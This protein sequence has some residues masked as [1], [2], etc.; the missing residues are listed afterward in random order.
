MRTVTAWNRGALFNES[1]VCRVVN[2]DS[3]SGKIEA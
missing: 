3:P 1:I 2:S